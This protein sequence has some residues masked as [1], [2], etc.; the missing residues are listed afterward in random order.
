M[1]VWTNIQGSVSIARKDRVS[2]QE[3]INNT[4]SDENTLKVHTYGVTDEA[5]KYDINCDVCM[6]GYDFIKRHEKFLAA[7]KPVKGSLDITITLRL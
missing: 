3:V 1:S 2:I 5:Y 4:L 7:L 6:D